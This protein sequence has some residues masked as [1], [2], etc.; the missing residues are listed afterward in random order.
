MIAPQ[1]PVLALLL[2][3]L[4]APSQGELVWSAVSN[5]KS[6]AVL[7]QPDRLPTVRL[8]ATGGTISNRPG[9]R[10]TA[11]QLTDSVPNLDQ[12]VA[13]ES[14]Q[15]DNVASGALTLDQWVELSR[16]INQ[17]FAER[18]DLD[19]IVVSS[20]TD[21]LE[22]VAYFLHLTVR[23]V[24]GLWLWW[25]RCAHHKTS[26]TTAQP[27]FCRRFGWPQSPPR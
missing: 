18:A 9:G 10:L 21:T 13:I 26:A 6:K 27:I 22:E 1:R 25:G 5:A 11:K 23:T 24:T 2:T 7:G 16:R 8:V 20:G 19:G 12:H 15:F 17:L 4:L 3:L 14:E